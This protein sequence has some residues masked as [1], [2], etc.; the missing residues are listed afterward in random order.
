MIAFAL[1]VFFA[2]SAPPSATP[3]RARLDA[4]AAA[5]AAGDPD[6]AL[7]ELQ[8]RGPMVFAE[9]VEHQ[10]LLA[11]ARAFVDDVDG[12][13]AA[14]DELLAT[15]PGFTMPYTASP[16]VTVAFERARAARRGRLPLMFDVAAPALVPPETPIVVEVRR[17]S[18]PAHAIT[19]LALDVDVPGSG[20]ERHT[21]S[22]DAAA[23][24]GVVRFVVPAP[25]ITSS[26]PTDDAGRSGVLLRLQLR[27]LDV[28]GVERFVGAP[29]SV[30]VGFAATPSVWASPWVWGGAAFVM[31]AGAVTA[32]VI[33]AVATVP[34]TADVDI[35]VQR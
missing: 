18:D 27:G 12:A 5:I 7:V 3:L 35:T 19:L 14:F 32:A 16:R 9:F 15:D 24:D 20:D 30:P 34:D 10:R 2:T 25:S 28:E 23:D 22:L 17:R 29:V 31:V 33:V 4:A 1:C 21:Y 26:S 11:T 8:P 13:V 6:A